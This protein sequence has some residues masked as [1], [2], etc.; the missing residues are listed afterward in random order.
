M[1][2]LKAISTKESLPIGKI[3]SPSTTGGN[4]TFA[5]FTAQRP[6]PLPNTVS[7]ELLMQESEA[8]PIKAKYLSD[9]RKELSDALYE[10]EPKT[11]SVLRLAA[12][13]SQ[14][15]LARLVGT[16]QPHLARIEQGKNDPG[17]DMVAR[18]ATALGLND[19]D[20]FQAIR[21]QLTAIEASK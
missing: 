10:E 18:I 7:L 8:D 17:T 2:I 12:G 21:N 14:V 4:V 15:Q 20:V 13:L 9:A 16:S 5:E 19:V 11:L 3:Y 1:T 6:I